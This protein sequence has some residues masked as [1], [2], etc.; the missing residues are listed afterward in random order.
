MTDD[1]ILDQWHRAELA[2]T[3]AGDHD[4]LEAF[5]T[6]VAAEDAAIARFGIGLHNEAYKARFPANANTKP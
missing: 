4:L 3:Q 2:H 6:K 1:E 5:I